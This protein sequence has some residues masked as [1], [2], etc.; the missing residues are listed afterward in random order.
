MSTLADDLRAAVRGAVRFESG[1][2]ALYATDASNYRQVPIGIVV[3]R[4]TA[5]IIAA[6]GVCRAHGAPILAR[7][8]G[9]SIVGQCCNTAVILDTSKYLDRVIDIDVTARTARVEPGLT[10]DNLRAAAV[11][12]RLTFGP[13]PGTHRCCT[14]GG[15]IG[16]N[17]C[18]VHSMQADYYGSGPTTAHNVETLDVLTY[19]GERMRVGATSDAEYQRVLDTGGSRAAIYR[20]LKEF[21]GRYAP[22]IR[23]EFPDIP[24]RVS[25]YNLP[26]LLPENGFDVGKALV[27]SECTL[28][29]VLEA[30][31]RLVRDFPHR[32]LVVLGYPDIFEAA[33]VVPRLLE[34]RPIGL[35]GVDE[36]LVREDVRSGIREDRLGLLPAGR[37]WLLVEFGGDTPIEAR[38]AAEPLIAYVRSLSRQPDTRVLDQPEQQKKLW[39]IR[40]MGGPA[41]PATREAPAMWPGWDDSAV[42]PEKLGGYLRDLHAL[43]AKY[44][45]TA[46]LF[47]HFGQGCVHCR[48]SFDLQTPA[49][50][51]HFRSFMEEAADLVH[52]YG[53]SLSGE[54]G[55]GQARGE[56][57]SR[58]FSPEMIQAFRDF[59]SIWDPDW[60]M[61]PG[62]VVDANPLDAH[63]RVGPDA[64]QPTAIETHFRF[65][66]GRR[67]LAL[68]PRRC[69][70]VGKCR[71]DHDGTMCP[72][73]MV[74]RE[75]KHSTRGRARL[76]FEMLGGDTLT[77]GWAS[78]EVHEALDLCLSCKGCKGECPM[79]VDMAAYKAEF[80]SHYYE[81]HWRPRTA[82][83]FGR[84][85]V[86]AAIASRA[87]RL[88]NLITQT[89]GLSAVAKLVAGMP[90]ARRIP[91]F[92]PF[93]FRHWFFHRAA[94]SGA[95]GP[96][97]ILW[98]DTFTN[99]FHPETAVAAVRV[100]EDAGFEVRLPRAHLCCG[101]PLYDYGMLATA[102]RRLGR[103]VQSLADE[104]DEGVP[105]VALEPSCFA[106]FKDELLNMLPDDERARR[107]S[108]LVSSF[109]EFLARHVDC[110]PLMTLHRKALVH[111][112]CHQKA[113]V[114]MEADD[115]VITRLGLDYETIDSG[116][117]GMAGSFGFER[118]HYHVSQ[119]VGERRLLPAVRT[120]S[121][122]TL[123]I[124]DGFSCREQIA[125]ATDRHA[126]HLADVL[127][128]ARSDPQER[129]EDYPEKRQMVDHAA[130]RV[131]LSSGILWTVIGAGVALV[132]AR[133][134]WIRRKRHQTLSS[135]A[136]HSSH[137]GRTSRGRRA[138]GSR[139]RIRPARARR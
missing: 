65:P 59:K 32:T 50:V 7:G 85:D 124:A 49:G 35:E 94:P 12:H 52:R 24:R 17:S 130:A 125:Q 37:G 72:S 68:V 51:N 3:P 139:S 42:A 126:L 82:Y 25:G 77:G 93:T 11:R 89:R 119:A 86:W 71:K 109:G 100:L 117:C 97:V 5:D 16:N 121:K 66:D 62:K 83:A 54:H 4:T 46:D 132:A 110:L 45:Y 58:M 20:R 84:I 103:I 80:L 19:R 134:R 133:A 123:I 81:H 129:T 87:P 138:A 122:D 67:S 48:V 101:R 10:L 55:D 105:I 69:V 128:L 57:L 1:D 64:R 31:V 41:V 28:V 38:D 63:L 6:V 108:A 127:A 120:A 61:N 106:I 30:T 26:A 102:R 43:Y 104:I 21:Q 15:M 73:Y 74:T 60:K 27:G 13:D 115:Q 14:L 91:A 88:V 47:G 90:Q 40:E 76:L 135:A 112:H 33:D 78:Q 98:P 92:A 137:P 70:G 23:G 22:I 99:H 131:P 44:D 118:D 2:R 136:P 107:L 34:Y 36:M 53:G 8:A 9:T 96:R 111:G 114:G 29:F 116:C 113:L 39:E 18:G 56:L 79:Q 75:E 95:R